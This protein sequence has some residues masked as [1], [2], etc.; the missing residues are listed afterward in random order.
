MYALPHSQ[1]LH[2]LHAGCTQASAHFNDD[3]ALACTTSSIYSLL[4]RLPRA[5]Q[6]PPT[7]KRPSLGVK[8]NFEPKGELFGTSG[9][10]LLRARP[11][12]REKDNEKEETERQ[13]R[14]GREKTDERK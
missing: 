6:A 10:C 2:L 12:K 11:V 3:G 8:V 7:S 5:D 4:D 13:R 1:L 9:L 14:G